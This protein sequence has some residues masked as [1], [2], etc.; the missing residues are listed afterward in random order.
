MN[1]YRQ[2]SLSPIVYFSIRGNLPALAQSRAKI[3]TDK[4]IHDE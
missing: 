4:E 3:T 2:S 1:D